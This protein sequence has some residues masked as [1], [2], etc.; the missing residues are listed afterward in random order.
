MDK[1][2]TKLARHA[3]G[4]TGGKKMSYRN[5]FVTGPGSPDYEAWAH[6]VA[7][8][9]AWRQAG[10]E[11]TGGDDLFGLTLAGARSVLLKGETLCLEDFPT[12]QEVK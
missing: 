3:L 1:E 2:Q 7:S 10:N 4:L 6:M 9:H 11:M 8:G 12:P 5:H